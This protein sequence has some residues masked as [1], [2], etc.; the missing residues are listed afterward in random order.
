ML[1]AVKLQDI[2]LLIFYP[3]AISSRLYLEE[4]GGGRRWRR[5]EEEEEEDGGGGEGRRREEEDGGGP[6]LFCLGRR[7]LRQTIFFKCPKLTKQYCSI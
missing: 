2:R 3:G 5:R 4:E 1:A 7:Q 6:E